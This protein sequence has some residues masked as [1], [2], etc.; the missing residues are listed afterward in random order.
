MSSGLEGGVMLVYLAYQHVLK[1][2]TASYRYTR[3][4]M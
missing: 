1:E 4:S 2:H 3:S